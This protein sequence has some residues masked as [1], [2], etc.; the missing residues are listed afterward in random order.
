MIPNPAPRALEG[1]LEREF[2]PLITQGCLVTPGQDGQAALQRF[3]RELGAAATRYGGLLAG[4]QNAENFLLAQTAPSTERPQRVVAAITEGNYKAPVSVVGGTI[5]LCELHRHVC[6]KKSRDS[7]ED[8]VRVALVETLQ[9][10]RRIELADPPHTLAQWRFQNSASAGFSPLSGL[11]TSFTALVVEGREL[12]LAHVGECQAYRVAAHGRALQ[13]LSADHTLSADPEFLRQYGPDPE[14]L[15][16]MSDTPR[17]V[18][19]S[20]ALADI[21]IE[22]FRLDPDDTLLLCSSSL[23]KRQLSEDLIVQTLGQTLGH[24]DPAEARDKLLALPL[25][26]DRPDLSAKRW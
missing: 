25:L 15:A 1:E 26:G 4:A 21:Q 19:G 3:G 12:L 17:F 6:R 7:V 22:W 20:C 11:M 24:C 8:D 2:E 10:L 23:R 18:L 14:V 9:R 13:R 16:M 5:A